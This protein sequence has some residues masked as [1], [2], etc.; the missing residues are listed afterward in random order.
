MR[1]FAIHQSELPTG[2]HVSPSSW[3][4][5]PFPLFPFPPHRFPPGCHRAQ[6]LG[7]RCH[8]SDLHWSSVLHMVMYMFQRYSLKSSHPLLLPLSPKACFPC[9][10]CCPYTTLEPRFSS[11][12]VEL[13]WRL[14]QLHIPPGP[15]LMRKEHDTL[16]CLTDSSSFPAALVPD[17]STPFK[18]TSQHLFSCTK[19]ASCIA[20]ISKAAT[21]KQNHLTPDHS[22][23]P[24]ETT[25]NIPVIFDCF[26]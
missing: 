7:A 18:Q 21:K 16:S 13:S 11:L 6:G 24:S 3:N 22:L 25:I 10:L 8:T 20:I 19:H 2:T 12:E 14:L 9:F 4:P 5:F 26:T 23:S 1:V 17:D 15:T